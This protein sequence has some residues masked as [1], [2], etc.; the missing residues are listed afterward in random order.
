MTGKYEEP[1]LG[2]SNE[3]DIKKEV[4]R[5]ERKKAPPP[6]YKLK[7]FLESHTYYGEPPKYIT[8]S[9][10]RMMKIKTK[11]EL[12][13]ELKSRRLV[14][15]KQEISTQ[16]EKERAQIEIG[17]KTIENALI[18]ASATEAEK[19]SN[20]Q[21]MVIYLLENKI[22]TLQTMAWK[23][24]DKQKQLKL[25]EDINHIDTGRV[26]S[27]PIPENTVIPIRYRFKP[28]WRD[29]FRRVAGVVAFLSLFKGVQT[30]DAE[31]PRSQD[32]SADTKKTNGS[33]VDEEDLNLLRV[34]EDFL[35][36][37]ENEPP[38]EIDKDEE[39]IIL[40]AYTLKKGEGF[41]IG[42]KK[43]LREA[44]KQ[45]GANRDIILAQIARKYDLGDMH[46]K[47]PE[48]V[49]EVWA[50]KQGEREDFRIHMNEGGGYN[51]HSTFFPGNN[52]FVYVQPPE[53]DFA[54]VVDV[55][56]YK[57]HGEKTH[58]PNTVIQSEKKDG[59]SFT[60]LKDGRQYTFNIGDQIQYQ[61]IKQKKTDERGKTYTVVGPSADSGLILKANDTKTQFAISGDAIGRINGVKTIQN[62]IDK[63]TPSEY[64]G[65][66]LKTLSHEEQP[67]DRIQV[68]TVQTPDK[69]SELRVRVPEDPIE[70][71]ILGDDL[72]PK[73]PDRARAVIAWNELKLVLDKTFMT[74]EANGDKI[75][76]QIETL[77]RSLSKEN[78]KKDIPDACKR[79]VKIIET[80]RL[81]DKELQ[82]NGIGRFLA[83]FMKQKEKDPTD[84]IVIV[85]EE[86]IG[87]TTKH[88]SQE[89]GQAETIVQK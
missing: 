78:R 37:T 54:P 85:I 57:I 73:D 38:N 50:K 3:N 83:R 41:Y 67:P 31:A 60:I 70:K 26:P 32:I 59:Q 9:F 20:E 8:K 58:K 65:R 43:A 51:F 27:P 18:H 74:N 53:S 15:L 4:T 42:A 76:R 64:P 10:D 40:G 7:E 66:G 71:I 68:P 12:L 34:D 35:D 29:R 5:Q 11:D 1:K 72:M 79:I 48:K 13:E 52:F 61:T 77:F 2:K 21:E 82:K 55:S 47:N 75:K 63:P 16:I 28:T 56:G 25:L 24:E 14:I 80:A 87:K 22:K 33:M 6:P 69:E 62:P 86:E 23:I 84:R 46:L 44:L 81:V 19:I 39:K 88:S 30:S 89:V 45:P 36:N 17:K 49:I